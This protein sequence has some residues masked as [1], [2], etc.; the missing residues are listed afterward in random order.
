MLLATC[1][2][3]A[4]AAAAQKPLDRSA[5]A[6]PKLDVISRSLDECAEKANRFKRTLDADDILSRDAA[7]LESQINQAAELLSRTHSLQKAR[8]HVESAIATAEQIDAAGEE[9]TALREALEN[10]AAQFNLPRPR[11]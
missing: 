10:L 5:E 1:L 4:V 8:G 7:R 3:L 6:S 11:W 9:W 2:I